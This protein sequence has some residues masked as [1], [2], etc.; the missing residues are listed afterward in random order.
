MIIIPE[1]VGWR[2]RRHIQKEVAKH[3]QDGCF[4]LEVAPGPGYLSILLRSFS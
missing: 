4:V 1:K 3:I 2:K